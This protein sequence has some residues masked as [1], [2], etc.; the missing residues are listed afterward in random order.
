MACIIIRLF[1]SMKFNTLIIRVTDRLIENEMHNYTKS[2]MKS[3]EKKADRRH[4]KNLRFISNINI[5]IKNKG[6]MMVGFFSE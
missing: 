1:S 2:N 5:R 6:I 4:W 3:E